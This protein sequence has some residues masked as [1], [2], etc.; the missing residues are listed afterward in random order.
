MKRSMVIVGVMLFSLLASACSTLG[1]SSPAEPTAAPAVRSGPRLVVCEGHVA[2]REFRYLSFAGSGTVAEVLVQTGDTVSAGQVLARLGDREQAEAALASAE[3][4]LL[5]AQQDKD[6]LIRTSD[7]VRFQ[8]QV[9]LLEAEKAVITTGRAWDTVDTQGFQDQIDEASEAAAERQDDLETA[10]EDFDKYKDLSEDNPT[11]KDYEDKLEE[12]QNDYD[13]AVRQ[14]DELVNQH[15]LAQAAY[16]QAQEALREAQYQV[17][18]TRAGPDA[19]QLA[20]VEAQLANAEAQAAAAQAALD[21]RDLKA[22]FA[23]T[24]VDVNVLPGELAGGESWAVLLADFSVWY[25][26]TSDLTELEVVEIRVGQQASLVADALP[27]LELSGDVSEISQV[28]KEKSGDITYR[29]R[30]R[31][32]ESDARLLW[33]MTVEVTFSP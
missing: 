27:E 3:L 1:L 28:F 16:Q 23:G 29:V 31:V 11:R 10:Q 14:R 20:L 13:E 9:A 4:A 7:L 15:D 8:R 26:E 12:A 6:K 2:P 17:D 30:I 33:G 32:D 25:V 19:D 18:L 24:V 5:A 21:L 22:P